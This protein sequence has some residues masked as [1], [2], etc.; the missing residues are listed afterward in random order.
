MREKDADGLQRKNGP[1]LTREG[2]GSAADGEDQG[3]SALSLNLLLGNLPGMAYRCLHDARWTM[4]F[5]S[6]GSLAL[7][8]YSPQ[9]LTGEAG[10]SYRDLIYP[11]DRE[12]VAL[13]IQDAMDRGTPF[14]LTYRIVTASQDIKWVSEQGC[15]VYAASGEPGAREGF[16]SDITERIASEQALRESEQ[17]ARSSA[18]ELARQG[19]TLTTITES[20][21]AYVERADWKSAFRRL[22]R[23]ALTQTQS[24]YGFIGVVVNGQ[25]LRVLAF[26]GIVWDEVVNREFYDKAMATYQENG[27]LVFDNFNNLFGRAITTGQVVIANQPDQ[28]AHSSGR[29]TGHPPMH[30]FMGIP[31]HAGQQICGVVALAN[32]PG[33]YTE[34]EQHCIETLVKYAGGMCVSYQE[35]ELAL[36]VEREREHDREALQESEARFRELASN[37]REVFYSFDARTARVYYVS[38]AFEAVWGLSCE[39]LYADTRAVLAAVYP[40]DR[41]KTALAFS[42][43]RAGQQTELEFRIRRPDGEERWI[44]DRSYPVVNA[45]GVVVRIVGTATDITLRKLSE[46]ALLESEK[47]YSVLFEA[48]PVPMWVF[49]EETRR[50]LA[51]NRAAT[52]EYG[53][54]E[55]EFLNMTLYDLRQASDHALLDR[56][57]AQGPADMGG[58][59]PVPVLHRRKDGSEFSVLPIS[60]YVVYAGRPARFV[61]AVDVSAQAKAEKDLQDHLFTLQRSADAAQAITQHQTLDATMQEVADQ[62]R[63]VIGT[64]QAVVSVTLDENWAQAITSLS[65]S[66]KYAAWRGYLEKADGSGIYALVCETNRPM[67]LTQQELESHPRWRGFGAHKHAHPAMQGW[68]A[69]PL[70]G[71]D[72]RNMGLLQLSDKYEGEFTLQDEYVAVEL[73]QLASIAIENARLFEQ[74]RQLNASLE[75]KVAE[76]TAALSRQE[77]LFRALAEQAPEMVWNVDVTGQ[78]TYINRRWFDMMGGTAEDWLGFKWLDAVHPDDRDEVA[79]NWKR[80]SESGTLYTGIRRLQARDGSY[81]TMSYRASPVLDDNGKIAF[82]VGIDADITDIKAAETALRLSNHE[83]EAFSYSVSHD[84]RSPLNTVAGF[85]SLLA[86]NLGPGANEKALHYLARIQAG[87]VQMGELIEGLLALSQVSRTVLTLDAVDLSELAREILERHQAREPGRAVEVD[88]QDGLNTHGDAHL[89]RAAMENLLANAWKFTSK[90]P[91]ALIRVG[92]LE[93]GDA[94]F[95]SDNGAGFDMAYADKLFGTFQRLHGVSEFPGT[96]VGL[97]TVSRIIARHGG[98]IWASASPGKGATFFFTLPG[99]LSDSAFGTLH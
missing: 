13:G 73:A 12:Q 49:D 19:E 8:G 55:S 52:Q 67:R 74:V 62:A 85:S 3:Y 80:S 38:P 48:G 28:H 40:D 54:S 99:A 31:I 30:S 64:H 95:V 20:L 17:R 4:R 78:L 5:V 75:V 35:R 90:R 27:Y 50:F 68:L 10:L 53:Y 43:Q 79:A 59:A 51:V 61:V 7:T 66:D 92:Q 6:L 2:G 56:V 96:G 14:R 36:A 83:L 22:L 37:V 16:I 60:R 72:G 47:R 26:D 77:A 81:R 32:R 15:A 71:S 1:P 33:G 94:F 42:R 86:R 93:G 29:P 69:V 9:A 34:K 21:A 57:L 82:W 24:E 76:R 41:Q 91:L 87:V 65:L 89:L 44:A 97:A 39:S 25:K 18:D 63:G 23:G 84:L 98:R 88:I 58:R 11:D 46:Q 45:R 70:T